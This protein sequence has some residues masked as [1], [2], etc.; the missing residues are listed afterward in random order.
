MKE[1]P[2]KSGKS[3]LDSIKRKRILDSRE[4]SAIEMGK[5]IKK[6]RNRG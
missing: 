5:N 2:T 4:N 3:S 1:V 6:K